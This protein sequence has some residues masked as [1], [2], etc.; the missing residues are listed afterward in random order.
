M[1]KTLNERR[2]AIHSL[3]HLKADNHFE[4][5]SLIF[6]PSWL[7]RK[8]TTAVTE[9]FQGMEVQNYTIAHNIFIK[10]YTGNNVTAAT[11]RNLTL[12]Q[13]KDD[14]EDIILHGSIADGTACNYSDFDCLVILKDD[15]LSSRPRLYRAASKLWKWQK[16]MLE[17]DILQHH[18]WFVVLKS[19][20]NCWD[21]T[22]LPLE[23][24][25]YSRSLLH[26]DG[27]D[28]KAFV[29]P[30]ENFTAPF[31]K[32]FKELKAV[33]PSQINRMNIY[34][35]K[36]FI[37]RF[38]LMPALYYQAKCSNGI[39]KKE[40]FI[41][42]RKDFAEALWKPVTELSELRSKWQLHFSSTTIKLIKKFYLY[43]SFVKRI[44]YPE[45]PDSI[46]KTVIRNLKNIHSLLDAMQKN[47]NF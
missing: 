30:S 35:L 23:V 14:I 20:F 5:L 42:A 26:S 47:L 46:K 29:N 28:L 2:A 22:Y 18:G 39:Y 24:F 16:L 41:L 38:F 25:R 15:I 33:T 11:L 21:Q 32:L 34:E 36:T 45:T 40:S 37:S 4:K 27:Y 44:F 43:P 1:N 10:P 7:M 19:D 12:A 9:R 8:K 13:L 17:T 3:I 31:A 6:S